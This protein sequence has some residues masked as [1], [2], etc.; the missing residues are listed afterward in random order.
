LDI[1]VLRGDEDGVGLIHVIQDYKF[2]YLQYTRHGHPIHIDPSEMHG[3]KGV[4]RA[5]VQLLPL[6]ISGPFRKDPCTVHGRLSIYD[7]S[8]QDQPSIVS[9]Y[10]TGLDPGTY[11]LRTTAKA[12]DITEHLRGRRPRGEIGIIVAARS[13]ISAGY[14]NTD[15]L[16]LQ[17]PYACIEDVMT[18]YSHQVALASGPIKLA[19]YTD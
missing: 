17:G 7:R 2:S 4:P 12:G 15:A 11:S 5:S 16:R 6:Q 9:Y 18:V 10:I 13:G 19:A 8:D 14:F 1:I 3:L